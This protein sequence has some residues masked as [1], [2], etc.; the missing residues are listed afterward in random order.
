MSPL[1]ASARIDDRPYR[2]ALD[3][4]AIV[5]PRE[6]H[7]VLDR[8]V[9][10][11]V[12]PA[13]DILLRAQ[14]GGPREAVGFRLDVGLPGSGGV[15]HGHGQVGLLESGGLGDYAL[16]VEATDIDPQVMV[17]TAP[18]GKLSV[19]VRG[20]G[21]GTPLSPGSRSAV[22]VTMPP[23][24]VADLRILEARV[25]A[26]TEGET[27][28]LTRAFLRGAGAELT[29]R[30]QGQG[31]QLQAHLRAT[32]GDP[33]D[34]R[35][36]APDFRGQ[37]L[38]TADL[39]GTLPDD[40]TFE[41]VANARRVAVGSARLGSL[42]LKVNGAIEQAERL[43]I[44]AHARLDSIRAGKA[45][46]RNALVEANVAGPLRAPRGKLR[47][48]GNG[49]RPGSEMPPLDRVLLALNSDG[50][51]VR[52]HGALTGPGASGGL[53]ARGVLGPREARVTLDR[54]ALDLRGPRLKQAVTL[55]KPVQI[56][57][58]AEDTL[59][60]GEMKIKASGAKLSGDFQLAG[61]YRLDRRGRLEPRATA[62]LSLRRAVMG[63]LDPI[64]AD[65]W[66]KLAR[67]RLEGQL[68]AKIA[69]KA[70]L[71]A[72]AALPLIAG[73]NGGAPRLARDGPLDVHVKTNQIKIQELPLLHKQLARYGWSGGTVNLT[74]SVSGDVAHPDATV[75]FDLREVELRKV[76]GQGRDS[77]VRRLP[78]VGAA[79][80]IDTQRGKVKASGQALLYRAG[81]LK[82]D[83][84][85]ETDL[86]AI[87]AGADP[88]KAPVQIQVDIPKFQ[89]ASLKGYFDQLRDTEGILAGEVTVRGTLARPTGEGM[90]SINQAR[91]EKLHFG[92]I[93]VQ[94][95]SDGDRV[96]GNLEIHQKLGGN[97]V[98][99]AQ[100]DR[101][102][103]QPLSVRAQ[104]K[105]LDV[106]F[107]RLFMTGVREIAGLV[108]ADVRV[109][110]AEHEPRGAGGRLLLQRPAGV[111]GTAD[112]PR[113]GGHPGPETRTGGHPEGAGLFR[114]REP[115]RP[116]LDHAR[117]NGAHRD[118]S[119][120]KSPPLRPGRRG[121]HRGPPGRRSRGSGGAA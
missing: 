107:A 100:L 99:Q 92:P 76:T 83:S 75:A 73:R 86:G 98:A 93:Q 66:F 53:A 105:K 68:D 27:W 120:R 25:D 26:A 90:V 88:L 97:L 111:G 20:R 59:E 110:G 70:D 1:T 49:I 79:I 46:A 108:D 19:T 118:G 74:A 101:N 34:G 60:L 31:K 10:G 119:H 54:F 35:L 22:T 44:A 2:L 38:L 56:R 82:F 65:G 3:S 5:S 48:V 39:R 11:G 109:T 116:G 9:L 21:A 78:G 71:R 104:A 117:W 67:T 95:Q 23:S 47:L 43:S 103:S 91:V 87:L 63:G 17:P 55:Q 36:P 28:R 51:N 77:V 6:I 62:S 41:A 57:W 42:A 81:F 113:H 8:L 14:V 24:R 13:G 7:A 18:P 16:A 12:A 52:L 15:V 102:G 106:T 50:K 64:D 85:L 94:A 58:R 33:A 121:Q 84:L 45:T 32:I 80:N 61:M 4:R 40:L 29:A 69:G 112:L 96:T 72:S 114:R 89:I 30:G 115:P 37:G